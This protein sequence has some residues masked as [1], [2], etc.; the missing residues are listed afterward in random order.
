MIICLITYDSLL[1]TK[2]TRSRLK[3]YARYYQKLKTFLESQPF[4][5]EIT[6]QYVKDDRITGNFEVTIVE[7]QKLIH[8]NRRGMGYSMGPAEMNAIACH[9]EDAIE[10]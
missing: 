3:G 6:V 2:I 10:G 9:I 1:V 4:G 8:S 7:T 5:S